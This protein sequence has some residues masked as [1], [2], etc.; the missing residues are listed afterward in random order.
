MK[1]DW[2]IRDL[3]T[4]YAENEFALDE[5]AYLYHDANPAL[6]YSDYMRME[7][8]PSGHAGILSFLVAN[9]EAS[10]LYDNTEHTTYEYNGSIPHDIWD[11]IKETY[12][13][14]LKAAK[15]GALYRPASDG[16]RIGNSAFVPY[17]A[18]RDDLRYFFAERL[19]QKPKFLFPEERD[20]PSRTPT[21]IEEDFKVTAED[22]KL[23]DLRSDVPFNQAACL[24][25]DLDPH[26]C[27]ISRYDFTYME[28]LAYH[29]ELPDHLRARI[30]TVRGLLKEARVNDE[31][32]PLDHNSWMAMPYT[33]RVSMENLRAYAERNDFRSRV[34][35]PED[36]TSLPN[37][38]EKVTNA[39][40]PP[41]IEPNARP[42]EKSE[43]SFSYSNDFR[44]VNW[45]GEAFTFTSRQA[46]IVQIL[47]EAY[48]GGT[49]DVGKDY[50][51]ESLGSSSSRLRDSF[52][53][54][55]AWKTLIVKGEKQGTYRLNI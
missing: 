47:F 45:K 49:P 29:K 2:K 43:P 7:P 23:W 41:P 1:D 50:I 17:K 19:G 51:L 55:K 37:E 14:L 4:W 8:R 22:Y 25:L 15:T 44:S 35:F 53:K 40:M 3:T 31:F 20:K 38:A 6:N 13:I 32:G 39:D 28:E 26:K 24:L 30:E 27:L 12:K 42:E 34:L 46:Q 36:R 5:A 16:S 21:S 9:E 54:S 48:S 52:R 11:K 33:P 10:R 18:T